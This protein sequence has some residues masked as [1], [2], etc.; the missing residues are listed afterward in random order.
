[1]H[2]CLFEDEGFSRLL[3]LVYFRPVYDLRCGAQLLRERVT[4]YFPNGKVSLHTRPYLS[5][6]VSEANPD[7]QVNALPEKVKEV[8][9][10]NGRLLMDASIWKMVEQLK[11]NEV[12]QQDK[13]IVAARLSGTRLAGIKDQ[14]GLGPLTYKMFPGLRAM[15]VEARLI[16][17]PWELIQYNEAALREDFTHLTRNSPTI[18]GKVYEGAVLVNR[19]QIHIASSAQVKPGAVL[20]ASE[21]PIYLDDDVRVFPNAV[22]EGPL[23]VGSNS[24]IKAG[25]KIY[26]NTSIGPVCKVGGEV[27]ESILHS[28][29]NKQHEGFLG[30][31]YLGSW[32]NLGADTNNSD[33]KNDYGTV[34]VYVQGELVDT[35]SQFVG[36]TMGDHSKSGINAMFNT[37]TVVGVNCNLYGADLPPKFVPSFTWGNASAGFTTYRLEKAIQV[38][39]RVMAR[40]K[41][42]LTPAMEALFRSVFEQSQA[43]R[44]AFGLPV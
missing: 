18:Q 17:Y 40:R 24:L 41:V 15:K 31:A 12:L 36:L 19:D 13:T 7:V 16:D 39:R 8:V 26:E 28:Y 6:V 44:D 42:A 25:A 22:L 32:V 37:G 35:G 43:E 33:L 27:E 29:S 5:S 14:M 21:G 9:F 10:I 1:M 11:P 34:K 38:A 3:P 23:Y 30:H 20:D 2:I 4:Q